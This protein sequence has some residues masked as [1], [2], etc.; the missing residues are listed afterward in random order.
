MPFPRAIH[1]A[2]ALA[3]I[4]GMASTAL[5]A[6]Q[7]GP[8][9]RLKN[10][11]AALAGAKTAGRGNG[12]PGLDR[13]M[14][15]VAASYRDMGL[16][17]EIQTFPYRLPNSTG[18]G[19]DGHLKN[20][21]VKI[22]GTDAEL[23]S[24]HIVVGAHIDHL[25]T[26]AALGGRQ[27]VFHGADDNASGSAAL[28]EL[29]RHFHGD[30]PA[31]SILFIHF[32][33]EEWGMLGSRHWVANPTVDIESVP[34]ML[35]LDMVGRLKAQNGLT[36]TT[37]GVGHDDIAKAVELAPD[38]LKVVADRGTSIFALASD[39]VAFVEKNI[40][41]LFLFTGVHADYHRTTDTVG[42]IDWD[43]LATVT[44]YAKTLIAEYA[45]APQT[46]V[47]KPRGG[48]GAN[49]SQMARSAGL[50]AWRLEAG[51]VASRAGMKVGDILTHLGGYAVSTQKELEEAL[52]SLDRGDHVTIRWRR[53]VETMQAD[54][55]LQ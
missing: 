6:V 40:P 47:F 44:G 34:L 3:G 29:T 9:Y 46:P 35:N 53:G 24:Q 28:M 27:D 7:D 50:R 18:H 5:S 30:P 26:K 16:E 42:K 21:A 52:D 54:L 39:H 22:K 51:G 14:E 1:L 32:S 55:E 8:K 19:P 10:D 13:A 38:G 48:L 49:F 23:C 4:A 12:Q 2:A 37:M 36:L 41:T 15:Y 20:L 43:G 33:G 17:P 31:R 11:V 25:G 45:N